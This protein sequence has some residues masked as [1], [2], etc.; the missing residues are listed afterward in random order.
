LANLKADKF[1]VKKE[2]A[3]AVSQDLTVVGY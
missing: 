3:E 2:T 1:C